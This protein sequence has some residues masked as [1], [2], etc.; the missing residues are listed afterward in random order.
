[1]YQASQRF[2]NF[3]DIFLVHEDWDP[4]SDIKQLKKISAW[5]QMVRDRCGPPTPNQV[6][7]FIRKNAT[8]RRYFAITQNTDE[9]ICLGWREHKTAYGKYNIVLSYSITFSHVHICVSVSGCSVCCFCCRLIWQIPSY[10]EQQICLIDKAKDNTLP[11]LHDL[12]NE[13]QYSVKKRRANI[14]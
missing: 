9:D 1:M 7:I 5:T 11:H 6:W 2:R 8:L 13:Q 14:R 3:V 4:S 10:L 12:R